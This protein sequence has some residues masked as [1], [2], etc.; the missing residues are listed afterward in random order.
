MSPNIATGVC[1]PYPVVS[2]I[3]M[4]AR[5]A[6]VNQ[7]RFSRIPS[8]STDAGTAS[9]HWTTLFGILQLNKTCRTLLWLTE[10][11]SGWSLIPYSKLH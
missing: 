11:K 8:Q 1:R 3:R 7:G 5:Q 9:Y 10:A 2:L 6:E 4:Q